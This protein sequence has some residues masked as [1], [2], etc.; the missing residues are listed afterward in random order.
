MAEVRK[1]LRGLDDL[2]MD[3]P[4]IL[5]PRGGLSFIEGN[6]HIPFEIKRVFYIYDVP[7]TGTRGA[8]AHYELHQF[9]ICLT[10]SFDVEL[11]NGEVK[12]TFSLDR[13]WR[14]LWIPPL[15]WMNAVHFQSGTVC[16]GL[17]SE[18]YRESDYIRSYSE[19]LKAAGRNS[20]RSS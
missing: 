2:L 7:T 5:E 9:L 6:R 3:L 12:R 11:E 8:H 14:G 4:K 1:T 15:V 17:A 19:F 13:P 18:I 16:L 20:L 10:G